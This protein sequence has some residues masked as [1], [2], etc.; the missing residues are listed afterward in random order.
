MK[1]QQKIRKELNKLR[2]KLISEGENENNALNLARAAMNE[3]YGHTWRSEPDNS[4]KSYGKM[5]YYY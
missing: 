2:L 5:S 3:K 4:I 1:A